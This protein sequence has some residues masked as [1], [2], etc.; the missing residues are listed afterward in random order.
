MS[1]IYNHEPP[2]KGKLV[3]HTTLGDIEIELWPKE[4]PKVTSIIMRPFLYPYKDA[5]GHRG[6][7]VPIHPE[8]M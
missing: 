8:A 2:T 3:L 7:F 1:A 6:Q 5:H 4:A